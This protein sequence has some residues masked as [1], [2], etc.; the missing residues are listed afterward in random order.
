MS[1][2]AKDS[3]QHCTLVGEKR[4]RDGPTPA[5]P[6]LPE[7]SSAPPL[8]AAL[9]AHVAASIG[10]SASEYHRLLEAEHRLDQK[11]EHA[12]QLLEDQLKATGMTP[13]PFVNNP[14]LPIYA[15]NRSLRIFVSAQQ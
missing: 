2:E 3:M 7:K 1:R 15:I 11:L 12:R 8:S 14:M 13:G 6:T 5:R 9:P 10:Q 4:P